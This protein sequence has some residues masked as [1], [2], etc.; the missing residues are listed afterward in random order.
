MVIYERAKVGVGMGDS[1][2]A[3]SRRS[4][5]SSARDSLRSLRGD[6]TVIGR[7]VVIET[8]AV[9]EAA[10]V[11]EGSLIEAGVV[12]GRGCVIGKVNHH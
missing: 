11:G 8:G 9:V 12:L 1:A 10:E 7:N 5:V 2:D 4:S 6:G 3:A